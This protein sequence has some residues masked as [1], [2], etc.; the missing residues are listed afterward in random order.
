MY[1]R[2]IRIGVLI[3][4][5]FV[6]VFAAG[7]FVN[8]EASG[9]TAQMAKGTLP[10]IRT[11]VEGQKMNLMR[12][13]AQGMEPQTMRDTLTPLEEDRSLSIV[14]DKSD[15]KIK[16]LS[17]K[18]RTIDAS[19]LIED[20]EIS[21]YK[22]AEEEI[23]ATL[24]IKNLLE[25]NTEYLLILSLHFESGE[26]YEYF[27]RIIMQEDLH[28]KEKIEFIQNFHDLTFRKED[29]RSIVKN[30]ESNSSGDNQHFQKVNIHSSFDQVTF[31]DLQVQVVGEEEYSILDQDSE[32]GAVRV[33]YV[34]QSSNEAGETEYYKV[35]EYYRVRYTS[36]RMYLL[37]FERT[38][39]QYFLP[40]N[41]VIREKAIELGVV[42]EDT[43]YAYN[44]N[45][46]HVAFVTG[47]ELWCYDGE[48]DR[49]YMVFSF[50]SQDYTDVRTN[51]Q[52]HDIK[53][54][55]VAENGDMDFLV[56]G[57]MSRGVHEGK[58]G[59]AVYR[60]SKEKNCIE[61]VCFIASK[62]SMH[63][64]QEDVGQIAYINDQSELFL[65]LEGTVYNIN[66]TTKEHTLIAEGLGEGNFAIS[67]S[68]SKIAWQEGDQLYDSYQIHTMDL[69]TKK[70][71]LIEV[72]QEE[73]IRP[74]GFLKEDFIYGVAKVGHISLDQNLFPMYKICVLN[75]KNELERE[76]APAGIYVTEASVSGNVITMERVV[77]GD[78]GFEETTGD[79]MVNNEIEETEPVTIK[80]AKSDL[81][82]TQVQIRFSKE[83]KNPAPKLL[84]PKQVL[85]EESRE[86]VLERPKDVGRFYV[87]AK[88]KI[89]G[90][91]GNLIEA[92]QV[93]DEHA[94][95]VL[96]YRMNYVWERTNRKPKVKLME[97]G[98][99]VMGSGT[100][101]C[102]IAINTI[103]QIEGKSGVDA[104]SLLQS[105]MS[106]AHVM[107]Q[108]LPT[109]QVFNLS[110]G[111]LHTALYYVNRGYPVL[112]K[113]NGQKM[114][115]IVGY[116]KYNTILM[117]PAA[118]EVY[119]YGINDSTKMFEEAGNIFYAYIPDQ[120]ELEEGEE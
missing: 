18:I 99:A 110:G 57:Y 82:K 36:Q 48:R 68:G 37:D 105:G 35:Q 40:D 58:V 108:G 27:T 24:Q 55:S 102:S 44:E 9:L 101:S 11:V 52:E 59:I 51:E 60:F 70:Q 83:V 13:Y 38:M 100:N 69:T 16:S 76:Y 111:T 54:L 90:I 65:M 114:C 74:L 32:V 119:Y 29:A 34:A 20:T 39:D 50:L 89:Q 104:E 79:H 116:D 62:E 120:K 113:M 72:S 86:I 71:Y 77:L 95:V 45:G 107:E 73:R 85:Y 47:G 92:V 88:G 80:T 67:E 112:A 12:G 42:E 22:E 1:K 91:Y 14:I 49:L 94:G 6:T 98:P 78:S 21:D 19:N 31:G 15:R 117:D 97:I 75:E 118:G 26:T 106:I 87:F 8:R 33:D 66:L 53:I 3:V 56:Y 81:K 61:E 43:A 23:Q 63:L 84:T 96:N 64:L 10:V 109:A 7:Y 4:V 28:T 2:L 115:L 5:F 25:E 17:Y 46:T 41:Q 30:L 103:F 93:A